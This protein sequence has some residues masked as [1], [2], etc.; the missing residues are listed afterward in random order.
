[1]DEDNRL[2]NYQA[3]MTPVSA[4]PTHLSIKIRKR[5]GRIKKKKKKSTVPASVSFFQEIL[6]PQLWKTIVQRLWH[7]PKK[8]NRQNCDGVCPLLSSLLALLIGMW[9]SLLRPRDLYQCL[10]RSYISSSVQHCCYPVASS[11]A[12]QVVAVVQMRPK[13]GQGRK[14]LFP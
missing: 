12:L 11:E 7:S 4:C 6:V 14:C 9:S 5:R 3:S 2:V 13:T 8:E 10:T 1:M